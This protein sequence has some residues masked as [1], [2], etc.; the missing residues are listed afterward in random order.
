MHL[1]YIPETGASSTWDVFK[2]QEKFMII[3]SNRIEISRHI[4]HVGNKKWAASSPG[5][6][7]L[8]RLSESLYS[9]TALTPGFLM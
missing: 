1:C 6:L 3:F 5:V 9:L 8:E 4:L 7:R 2:Q